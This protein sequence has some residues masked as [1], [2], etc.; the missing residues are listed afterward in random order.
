MYLDARMIENRVISNYLN[1]Q[2]YNGLPIAVLA[3]DL[4]VDWTSL[5]E[6]VEQL[7]RTDQISIAS[8]NQTNP[9]I[10]MFDV[11]VEEQ[12]EG[13]NER[14]PQ[15]VCLYP[16]PRSMQE[17]IN[18]AMF[19]SQPFT[20]MM[21]LAYPKLLALPFRLDLV[22]FYERD[23]RYWFRFYDFGGTIG[24]DSGHEE[25]LDESDRINLRFGVGYDD[26]C[27]RVIAVYLHRLAKLPEK[28]Q[29]I[30]REFLIDRKCRIAEE[31]FLTTVFAKFPETMSFYEVIIQEQVEIN[32]LFELV[33]HSQ[34]FRETYEEDRRP[35]RFNIFCEAH[36]R[37]TTRFCSVVGQNVV[38]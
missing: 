1:S 17:E 38:G 32:K 3:K 11:P 9:F 37:G 22:D 23:P 12:L 7:V 19:D 2:D 25:L 5:I 36:Q 24:V 21:L 15:T 31:F 6:K 27:D 8:P 33:G 35:R 14:D 18:P 34:L 28:Q 4:G 30:W 20:K 10:K 13:L 29:R 26:E 16:T